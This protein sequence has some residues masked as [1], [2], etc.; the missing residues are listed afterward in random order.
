MANR[1][2]CPAC[3]RT[4]A[5]AAQAGGKTATCNE[6][7]H[8]FRVRA[9]GRYQILEEIGRGSFGVVYRVFD[10]KMD[11]EAAV[12]ILHAE[13]AQNDPSGETLHRFRNEAKLLAQIVHPN[14]LPLYE[15]DQHN[16]Q[17]YL[18]T[19]L[20]RGKRLDS[21]IP[22]GGFPD[23]HR[24]VA[25][26][27]PLL[28]ALH[29]VHT[30]YGICHRDVKPANVMVGDGDSLFLMDFG[31]AVCQARDTSRITTSG[32]ALG[33][34]AYMPPEQARG[35]LASIGPWSDQY[36]AGVV[37]FHL[38]T[39][40][41]PFRAPLPALL[42]E[43]VSSPAPAPSSLRP[44]LGAEL[45]R[46]VLKALEKDPGARHQDCRTLAEHLREWSRGSGTSVSSGRRLRG[47]ATGAGSWS[48]AA[49]IAAWAVLAA[50][51]LSTAA[52]FLWPNKG[53]P[54][55]RPPA[56]SSPQHKGERNI[57]EGD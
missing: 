38:L 44:D 7:G 9:I 54:A 32:M 23:P 39:G 26:A 4:Y 29:Y 36:G 21:L 51:V 41:V 53:G 52:Y 50:A 40:Q 56:A 20:V 16:G 28:E 46:I 25:L 22:E 55:G 30:T 8:Q 31:L 10:P 6:C 15:A 45:D 13:V 5:L 35:D 27:L 19:A 43:I 37:L 24:A 57:W 11:R 17:L 3:G 14:I 42:G 49:A 12:K 48:K 33:T 1:V 47:P 34:P 2:R 18:V